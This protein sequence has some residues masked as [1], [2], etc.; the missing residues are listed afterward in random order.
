MKGH[1]TNSISIFG[2]GANN[3]FQKAKQ[4]AMKDEPKQTDSNVNESFQEFYKNGSNDKN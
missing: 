2:F 4:V 1:R 3:W